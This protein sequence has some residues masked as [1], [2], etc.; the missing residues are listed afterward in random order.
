[1]EKH[2]YLLYQYNLES[3]RDAPDSAYIIRTMI[4]L[5]H[6]QALIY[7]L[8][9]NDKYKSPLKEIHGLIE[10]RLLQVQQASLF[11]AVTT[12]FK[13]GENSFQ[14]IEKLR[15]KDRC[16]ANLRQKL[17]AVKDEGG[18]WKSL[19]EVR[20]RIAFHNN[21]K[22][23]AAFIQKCLADCKNALEADPEAIKHQTLADKANCKVWYLLANSIEAKA[24]CYCILG[25]DAEEQFQADSPAW[26]EFKGWFSRLRKVYLS[27]SKRLIQ[28]WL[29]EY[30][31][32]PPSRTLS[33]KLNKWGA[34]EKASRKEKS[35]SYG[36]TQYDLEK[37]AKTPDAA[38]I[39]RTMMGLNY[40]SAMIHLIKLNDLEFEN[41]PETDS[42]E[43][44]QVLKGIHD[45]IEMWIEAIQQASLVQA[46]APLS[47]SDGQLF[48]E[49]QR[50]LETN[51]ELAN[52]QKELRSIKEKSPYCT[53]LKEV[54]DQIAFHY[55][56]N[57][58]SAILDNCFQDYKNVLSIG[59]HPVQ[60]QEIR[61]CESEFAWFSVAH[62]VEKKAWIDLLLGTKTGHQ[63]R[64][65]SLPKGGITE[66]DFRE[67][68]KELVA[69][70]LKYSK[71][72]INAW[73]KEH[74]IN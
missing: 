65:S 55:N 8:R 32:T 60:Y 57:D 43:L 26:N 63:K 17:I 72:L 23:Q 70:Y 29:E 74:Q 33:L 6:Q 48:K 24:W 1:M 44:R 61:D 34:E 2:H 38:F 15:E 47:E 73:L 3:L 49:I 66:E 14:E 51:K 10:D 68:F 54:R 12:L 56:T 18:Y 39:L 46:L 67:W 58:D 69:T 64:E 31:V 20:N 19:L 36:I 62:A 71:A 30:Q 45:I 4:G 25:N 13:K 35:F 21:I 27:Y 37:I 41:A 40:Q 11:E 5:N 52:L 22:N 42:E 59:N 50:L 28:V 16:L 7:L 9:L 53:L